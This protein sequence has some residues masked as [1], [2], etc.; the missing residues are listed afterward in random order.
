[1]KQ[2]A[3]MRLFTVDTTAKK[4]ALKKA[5]KETQQA[6]KGVKDGKTEG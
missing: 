1:M 3:L 5:V 6:L 4:V 2:I